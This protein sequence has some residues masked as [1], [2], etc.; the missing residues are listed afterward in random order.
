MTRRRLLAVA[1]AM[2]VVAI[3]AGA[4]VVLAGRGD[5]G[6]RGAPGDDSSVMVSG[7]SVSA[8]GDLSWAAVPGGDRYLVVG[9]LEGEEPPWVWEGTATATR[10]GTEPAPTF[11]PAAEPDP[12]AAGSYRW[13][14]L[15]YDS[16]D[17]LV[18]ASTS[19]AFRCDGEGCEPL[20]ADTAVGG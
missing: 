10:Y 17:R 16:S 11:D 1:G 13:N 2:V 8:E 15:A 20:A 9:A 6:G 18:A 4:V 7:L 3:V 5:G 14:V 12:V 19:A